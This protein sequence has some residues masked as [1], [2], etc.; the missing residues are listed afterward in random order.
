MSTDMS[1]SSDKELYRQHVLVCP[2]YYIRVGKLLRHSLDYSSIEITL[3]SRSRQRTKFRTTFQEI[4]FNLI[5]SRH[6]TTFVRRVY[7]TF[8]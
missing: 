4:S 8:A 7:V 3:N 2:F 5:V 6:S 1:I